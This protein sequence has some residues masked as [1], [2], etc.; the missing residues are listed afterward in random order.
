MY[1]TLNLKLDFLQ[2]L[3]KVVLV[4]QNIIKKETYSVLKMLRKYLH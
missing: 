4:L 2:K 1:I 3:I